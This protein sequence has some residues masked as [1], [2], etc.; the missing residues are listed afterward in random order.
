[1][2]SVYILYSEK[3]K[4]YYVGSCLEI[5]ERMAD[6]QSKKYTDSYTAKTNDWFFILPPS[7]LGLRT[8]A[9]C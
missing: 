8:S 9:I 1:M 6:H 2:A 4:K 7:K 5:S 3:L